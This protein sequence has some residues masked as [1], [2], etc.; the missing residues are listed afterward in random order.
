MQNGSMLEM[1]TVPRSMYNK[2]ELQNVRYQKT[3]VSWYDMVLFKRPTSHMVLKDVCLDVGSGEVM[4][5]MG[6]AGTLS[7]YSNISSFISISIGDKYA[8]AQ[9]N[10][11]TNEITK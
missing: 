11:V 9:T 7:I 3:E 5:V 6:S 8:K 1:S 2:L 10:E 4:A